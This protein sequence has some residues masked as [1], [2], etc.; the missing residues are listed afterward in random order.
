MLRA[1]LAACLLLT[2]HGVR[3]ELK[4]DYRF[5]NDLHSAI[6]GAPDLAPVASGTAFATEVVQCNPA[7]KVLTFPAGAG[8][9]LTPMNALL[10]DTG[11]YTVL[12]LVRYD[13]VT[14]F[15]K[16]LDFKNGTADNGLYVT[17]GALTFYNVSTSQ[18]APITTG[19]VDVGLRRD[20]SGH[21]TGY[22]D[23]VPK[24]QA[25]DAGNNLGVVDANSV[26]RFFVDDNGGSEHSSG[27]VARIRVWDTALSDTELQLADFA[28]C[29]T[30][31]NDG[32]E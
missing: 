31:F 22:L 24:V 15:R 10:P 4:A 25:A 1:V 17:N 21:V 16:Y 7:R 14:G 13:V 32:F 3:A 29:V 30:V 6:A 20:A 8:L 9:A 11:V 27:A 12:F 23:G 19:Y 18:D 2:V 28:E 5:Q 26:W